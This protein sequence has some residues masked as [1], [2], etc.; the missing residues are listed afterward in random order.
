MLGLYPGTL[1][2]TA[3]SGD[4]EIGSITLAATDRGTLELLADQDVLMTGG[5]IMTDAAPGVEPTPTD[6]I[7]V[8]RVFEAGNADAFVHQYYFQDTSGQ[9]ERRFGRHLGDPDPVRIYA[10]EGDVRAEPAPGGLLNT[11]SVVLP[12]S[13]E[14]RAGGDI[15][16]L[17]LELTNTNT[18]DVT[19][20]QAGGDI[21]FA[22]G[23]GGRET[24]KGAGIILG[25]PGSLVVS[26]GGDIYLGVGRGIVTDGNLRSLALPDRGRTSPSSP[27]WAA[28]SSRTAPPS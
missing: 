26:A 15:R 22:S 19:S 8:G 18:D 23:E 24:N 13:L 6:P 14:L 10:A 1:R 11:R 16:D 28:T 9:T 21:D 4:I 2:A 25:G 5:L 17:A 12:K 20:I 3:F 7:D 27:G